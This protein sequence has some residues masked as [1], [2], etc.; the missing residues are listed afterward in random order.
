MNG[1]YQRFV[2]DQHVGAHTATFTVTDSKGKETK[3]FFN[4]DKGVWVCECRGYYYSTGKPKACCHTKLCAV[5]LGTELNGPVQGG[6]S[7]NANL[8]GRNVQATESH[9]LGG[10]TSTD[11]VLK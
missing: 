2:S 11:K 9:A 7:L 1:V 8:A 10:P 5:Q 6:V 4:F 3:V